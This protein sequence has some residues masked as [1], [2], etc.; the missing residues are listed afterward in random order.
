MTRNGDRADGTT[1]MLPRGAAAHLTAEAERYQAAGDYIAA[2]ASLERAMRIEP[3][4]PWLSLAMARLRLVEGAPGQAE[5]LARRA[6]SR[7]AGDRI[8]TNRCWELVAQ[9]RQAGGDKAGAL[10]A[11]RM[12]DQHQ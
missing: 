9:A 11:A 6:L 1:V 2:A 12:A 5:M 4:N 7:A 10:E 8:L 3:G